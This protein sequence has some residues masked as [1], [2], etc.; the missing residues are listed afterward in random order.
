M[1]VI[2]NDLEVVVGAEEPRAPEDAARGE[3]AP[4]LRP[5]DIN[6]IV[7]RHLRLLTRVR[8]H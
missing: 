7:E 5:E 3:A 8:A 6:D 4:A 1:A 2:I